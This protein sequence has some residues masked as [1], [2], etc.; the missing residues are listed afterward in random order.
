MIIY[1]YDD[2]YSSLWWMYGSVVPKVAPLT[3]L[4]CFHGIV[5]VYFK[6]NYNLF[7]SDTT[8]TI[9]SPA[10]AIL[11]IFKSVLSYQHYTLAK[12]TIKDA[13]DAIRTLAI[14][15]NAYG[16]VTSEEQARSIIKTHA[17]MGK[18]IVVMW[19]SIIM[20]L[21]RQPELPKYSRLYLYLYPKEQVAWEEADVRP[22]YVMQQMG[23]HIARLRDKGILSD[24]ESVMMA[25]EVKILTQIFGSMETIRDTPTLPFVFFQ[26]CNWMALIYSLSVPAVIATHDTYYA[27][28]ALFSWF[29]A[30]MIFGINEMGNL[31]SEPFGL[32][33]NDVPMER[34]GQVLEQELYQL[35]P[36]FKF[37]FAGFPLFVDDLQILPPD[38][39]RAKPSTTLDVKIKSHWVPA[40]NKILAAGRLGLRKLQ[41]F[42][43][44]KPLRESMVK[45]FMAHRKKQEQNDM[46]ALIAALAAAG[47]G[48]TAGVPGRKG[49]KGGAAGGAGG[50]QGSAADTSVDGLPKELSVGRGRKAR[51]PAE[52]APKSALV[53]QAT[54][55][56]K[57]FPESEM[58]Q[59]LMT[60][61]LNE[62][63][64][65][66]D[67]AALL[68]LMS[69]E[70]DALA[71]E[72]GLDAG[73]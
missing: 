7:V 2:P 11:L 24:G 5:A 27:S 61:M 43:E 31:L 56:A 48:G 23:N 32:G 33:P 54:L 19:Y 49:A 17:D 46:A 3:I 10:V 58:M 18:H 60:Q 65:T 69:A 52:L 15:V 34:W 21:R 37:R 50:A 1:K 72:L 20:H 62:R 26:F 59:R 53:K 9:L 6:S 45:D 16:V 14:N 66:R 30:L 39:P 13:F 70:A 64:D 51:A 38:D 68:A 12:R 4:A 57:R 28:C 22:L 29:A 47:I 35:F 40:R 25:Q 8:H 42:R 63:V 44:A 73:S 41:R 67:K 36:W 55:L 71:A